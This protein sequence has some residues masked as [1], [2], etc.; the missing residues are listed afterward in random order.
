MFVDKARSHSNTHTPLCK[1][2][3]HIILTK[4]RERERERERERGTHTHTRKSTVLKIA[5]NTLTCPSLYEQASVSQTAATTLLS[6][7]NHGAEEP[8]SHL[9]A[10]AA[11]LVH[12]R[13]G[14][15][16]QAFLND[17]DARAD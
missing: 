12:R 7:H 15:W 3:I 6:V 4:Q 1:L 17:A 13:E 8:A 2:A 14:F 10:V 11:N 9:F 16:N 5:N